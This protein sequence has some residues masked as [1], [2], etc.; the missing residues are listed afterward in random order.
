MCAA[1]Q[2]DKSLALMV[3]LNG[4]IIFISTYYCVLD[5]SCIST[6]CSFLT[7]FRNIRITPGY[8]FINRGWGEK[9]LVIMGFTY[10]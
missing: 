1:I 5:S 2:T 8:L 9:K 10:Y 3:S 7:V 4:V 6:N